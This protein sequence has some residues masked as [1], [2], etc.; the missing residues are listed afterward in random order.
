MQQR[1]ASGSRTRVHGCHTSSLRLT[2]ASASL[3]RPLQTGC[4]AMIFT[5][6]GYL[7][8]VGAVRRDVRSAIVSLAVFVMYG[9]L[10]WALL[11]IR[12]R[13]VSGDNGT[14]GTHRAHVCDVS[15]VDPCLCRSAAIRICLL[16]RCL[17][18]CGALSSAVVGGP[19]DGHG[20]RL[21]AWRL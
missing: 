20:D 6:F 10:L 1:V 3:F 14:P 9:G 19:S 21:C 4:G 15:S 13:A 12:D 17:A 16:T 18:L 2:S 5:L 7:L 8:L 11:P